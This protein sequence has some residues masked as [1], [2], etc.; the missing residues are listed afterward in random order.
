MQSS[1]DSKVLCERE[2]C[3]DTFTRQ[4]DM[5]RHL[6][7]KHRDPKQCPWCI[8]KYKR[9]GR[10]FKHMDN[11][12]RPGHG[13]EFHDSRKVETE[14]DI[15]VIIDCNYISHLTT[16]SG[17]DEEA[18]I[19]QSVDLWTPQDAYVSSIQNQAASGPG[20]QLVPSQQTRLPWLAPRTTRSNL[21]QAR[22]Q[23]GVLNNVMN[24]RNSSYVVHNSMSFTPTNLDFMSTQPILHNPQSAYAQASP[25]NQQHQASTGFMAR[26]ARG[27]HLRTMQQNIYDENC[28]SNTV[29]IYSSPPPGS[30]QQYPLHYAGSLVPTS[31]PPGQISSTGILS[32]GVTATSFSNQLPYMPPSRASDVSSYRSSANTLYRQTNIPVQPL[33]SPLFSQQQSQPLN[34]NAYGTNQNMPDPSDDMNRPVN[35]WPRNQ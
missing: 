12:H 26:C 17:T 22:P 2:D 9:D 31:F 20:L 21:G 14:A 16:D 27:D 19:V 35:L 15:Y 23:T 3:P 34:F 4:R 28:S 24:D 5:L 29:Q 32:Q 10:L 11:E 13:G 7:E 6:N 33:A 18:E 8:K 25:M 30:S 1:H